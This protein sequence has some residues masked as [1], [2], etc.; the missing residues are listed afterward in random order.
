MPDTFDRRSHLIS[1]VYQVLSVFPQPKPE[2]P[3]A[4]VYAR[5]GAAFYRKAADVA[6]ADTPT[7]GQEQ[8]MPKANIFGVMQKRED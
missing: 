2:V 1:L 4:E 5:L 3:D 7:N 8:D 6:A